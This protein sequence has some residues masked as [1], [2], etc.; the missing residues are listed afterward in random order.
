MIVINPRAPL[1]NNVTQYEV[2]FVIP[3]NG[4][5]IQIG[6]DPFLLFKSRDEALRQL[7]FHILNTFNF[8]IGLVRE[9]KLRDARNLFDF[10]EVFEIGFGY[11]KKG[12]RGAGVGIY[13]SELIIQTLIDSPLLMERG[14]RHIE[15]MQLVSLGIGPDRISD[16]TANLIKD[17]LIK[18]TQKQCNL[19]KIP[20]ANDVPISHYFDFN[21]L[22]WQDGYFDLPLSPLDQSP[23]LFV[24]RRIVRA[25][26]WI[27][28][29]DYFKLEFAAFL[30]AKKV[31]SQLEIKKKST[32]K[33]L[34]LTQK[35]EVI[36]LTR[37]EIKRIDNYVNIKEATAEKAQPS[38]KY[39]DGLSSSPQIM[40]LKE[41]LGQLPT[42]VT[43]AYQY[44]RLI[45]EILNLLFTPELI[46]GEI[47]VRTLDG[48]ERRDIVFTNDSDQ[49]FWAFIRDHHSSV[50]VM[51]ETKNVNQI[52]FS[53]INQVSSYLGD[54]M[55]YLGFIVTRN[56]CEL[57][58]LRKIYSIYN[59]SHPRKIILVI[60]DK[61]VIQMLDM[62]DRGENPMQHL[63][64]IYRSF[65]TQ[66]Q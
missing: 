2:D 62:K 26:P 56:Q 54:R 44:Q 8:G 15:E 51:F 58:Q 46:D 36:A 63:Q 9:N 34:E 27:N 6:I 59:D 57:N 5:D 1:L 21:E 17:Y 35:L 20:L 32:I 48:T 41:Q 18:Y 53:H 42:G 47:E 50:F 61:D 11:T 52:N 55:G 40:N 49:S 65:V 14:V 23:M 31:R 16:I 25:L 38:A 60:S 10:P 7:H 28:Y 13:L 33:P 43:K 12:K 3:R 45:F 30:R 4:V 19:W 64:K 66:V 24:P 37:K 39:L 22:C 29:D